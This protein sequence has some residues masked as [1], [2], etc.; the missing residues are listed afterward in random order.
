M[1]N[2]YI[3]LCRHV[4]TCAGESTQL[5][6]TR[7]SLCSVVQSGL[8]LPWPALLWELVRTWINVFTTKMYQLAKN[9]AIKSMAGN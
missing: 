2:Y 3:F 6:V 7:S 5:R 9:E 8:L 1:E 4:Q